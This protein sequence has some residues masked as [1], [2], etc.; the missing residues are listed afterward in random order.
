MYQYS[1]IHSFIQSINQPI[2][3]LFIHSFILP[4]IHPRIIHCAMGSFNPKFLHMSLS[5]V[6]SFVTLRL[7]IL[8]L[9]PSIRLSLALPFLRARPVSHSTIFCGSPFPG[10]LFTFP[11]HGNRFP[12]VYFQYAL[13]HC[14]SCSK[15]VI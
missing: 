15:G 14:H 7:V 6:S 13:P 8:H 2:N 12:S 11:H 10:T 3:Q 1:C 4:S 9:T 5:Q